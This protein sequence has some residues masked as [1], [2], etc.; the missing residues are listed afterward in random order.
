MYNFGSIP[1]FA[2]NNNL[3]EKTPSGIPSCTTL[4][5]LTGDPNPGSTIRVNL[6]TWTNNP[7]GYD[8]NWYVNDVFVSNESSYDTTIRDVGMYIKCIIVASN[9]N[10]RSYAS[11]ESL[12]ITSR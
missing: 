3:I 4:P 9:L 8:Y 1:F 6:G 7:V 12:L 11:T 5:S 10:G 2:S